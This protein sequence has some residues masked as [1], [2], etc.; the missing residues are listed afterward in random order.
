MWSIKYCN[1]AKVYKY[2]CRVF[3]IHYI[4]H[5]KLKIGYTSFNERSDSLDR[6]ECMFSWV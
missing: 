1:P 2:F 3:H 6:S 4:E 5:M